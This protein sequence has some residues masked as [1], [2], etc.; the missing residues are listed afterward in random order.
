MTASICVLGVGNEL[1]TDEGFGVVAAR[2]VA[3][4]GLEGVEV[5]DGGTLGLGL[6]PTVAECESLLILDAIARAGAGPGEIIEL[7]GDEVPRY[8]AQVMSVHQIQLSDALAAAEWAG[9][10]PARI[11]AVGAVPFS[12]DTGYGLTAQMSDR[13]PAVLAATRRILQCWSEG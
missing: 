9:R 12:L 10:V 1:F 11:A 5:L 13:L 7:H 2:E 6:V 8:T 3:T 4:W